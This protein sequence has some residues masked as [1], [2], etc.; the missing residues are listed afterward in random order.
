MQRNQRTV[1]T[2][3]VKYEF[4]CILLIYVWVVSAFDA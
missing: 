2:T 3:A 4:E 1:S